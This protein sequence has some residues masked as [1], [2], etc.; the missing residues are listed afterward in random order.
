MEPLP[1]PAPRL[2]VYGRLTIAGFGAVGVGLVILFIGNIGSIG[3]I[4]TAMVSPLADSSTPGVNQANSSPYSPSEYISRSTALFRDAETLSHNRE[5]SEEDK[6]QILSNL[7]QALDTISEGIV[8]YPTRSELWAHRAAIERA[9]ISISRSA[10]S[11][12]IADMIRAV[13]LAPENQEYAR[14]LADLKGQGA[15]E[16]S[17]AS[18][19][20]SG[21]ALPAGLELVPDG[22][23]LSRELVVASPD[24]AASPY[25]DDVGGSAYSGTAAIPAGQTSV[26]IQTS[27][28]TDA[29]IYVTP[30]V[31]TNATLTVTTKTSG[32]YFVVAVDAVQEKDL[33]FNWW[34]LE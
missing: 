21:R 32:S 27:R 20:S 26:T 12:A 16:A 6:R 25:E 17:Q 9:V 24:E 2:P 4:E 1:Q 13:E 22:Y 23:T 34:I 5:Q 28:V 10:L 15:P 31:T 14:I 18:E 3:R 19:S 11:A 29:P 30:E 7:Q 8:T 33:P